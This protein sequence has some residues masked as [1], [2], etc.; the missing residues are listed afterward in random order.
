MVQRQIYETNVNG[1]EMDTNDNNKE[2]WVSIMKVGKFLR[3]S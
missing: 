2:E 3:R 1:E